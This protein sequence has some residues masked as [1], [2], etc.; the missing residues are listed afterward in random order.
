[1]IVHKF[2]PMI[3]NGTTYEQQSSVIVDSPFE[4]DSVLS[5]S[6]RLVI[7]RL[8]GGEQGSSLGYVIREVVTNKVGDRYEINIDKVLARI[9]A[10]GAKAN[11]S[12][13]ER[14]VATHQYEDDRAIIVLID[15]KTGVQ[16]TVTNMPASAKALFPHFRSDNWLY[17]LIREGETE[18]VVASDLAIRLAESNP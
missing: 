3:F 17:I 9:C 16:H 7:S 2:S 13:D 15:L 14:F 10:P 6:G 18:Y 11:I 1:M 12:F 8:A 4:G 5:P